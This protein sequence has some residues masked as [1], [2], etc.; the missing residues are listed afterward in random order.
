V[1]RTLKKPKQVRNGTAV[2]AWL[3][4][5][6]LTQLDA[7]VQRVQLDR[8]KVLKLLIDAITPDELL[9]FYVARLTTPKQHDEEDGHGV[10]SDAAVA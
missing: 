2:T 4:D 8:S 10:K 1:T 7:H 5:R 6:E 9:A 3:G